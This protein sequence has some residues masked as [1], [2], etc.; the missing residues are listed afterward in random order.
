MCTH[1][2]AACECRIP[3][4]EILAAADDEGRIVVIMDPDFRHSHIVWGRCSRTGWT[5]GTAFGGADF[6]E[7]H[8]NVLIVH[9]S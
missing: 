3:D 6:V 9:V 2:S 1:S 7:L 8:R 5:R 4:A